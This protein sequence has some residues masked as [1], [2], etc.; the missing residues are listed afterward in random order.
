MGLIPNFIRLKSKLESTYVWQLPTFMEN[1]PVRI[2]SKAIKFHDVDIKYQ[3]KYSKSDL[4][5]SFLIHTLSDCE[6]YRRLFINGRSKIN[7]TLK[8]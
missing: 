8:L 1:V 3:D 5:L 6:K 4:N 7:C 2:Q